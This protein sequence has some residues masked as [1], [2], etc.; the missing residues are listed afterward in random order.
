MLTRRLLAAAAI[1]LLLTTIGCSDKEKEEKEAEKAKTASCEG[2]L[3]PANASANLPADVPAGVT[4]ATFYD[5]QTDGATKRYFAYVTGDDVVKTRDAI[6][7]A[8]T[9]AGYEIEGTDEEGQ[10][11]AEFEFVKG[12]TEGSVQVIPHCTGYQRVRWRVGPK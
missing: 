3:T 7:N 1:P 4:G 5:L 10:A 9:G 6:K 8:F 12:S 2:K 11:E